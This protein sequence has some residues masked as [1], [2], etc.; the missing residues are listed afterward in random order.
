MK[1]SGTFP[2]SRAVA[3]PW[4]RKLTQPSGRHAQPF[5]Y[6]TEN[7]P[8]VGPNLSTALPL[9]VSRYQEWPSSQRTPV[10]RLRLWFRASILTSPSMEFKVNI[11]SSGSSR[12]EPRVVTT[13]PPNVVAS[14][15]M[16]S[17]ARPRDKSLPKILWDRRKTQTRAETPQAKSARRNRWS[18]RW[19]RGRNVTSYWP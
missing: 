1:G 15:L 11:V 2:S 13:A 14:L 5:L 12:V 10:A 3:K 6:G 18:G 16:N 4:R 8:K 17:A 7:Q 19:T 9:R